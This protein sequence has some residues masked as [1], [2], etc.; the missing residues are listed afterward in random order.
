MYM[1]V[2]NIKYN[3]LGLYPA[4]ILI[5]FCSFKHSDIETVET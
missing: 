4:D 2:N 3:N 1:I 5:F